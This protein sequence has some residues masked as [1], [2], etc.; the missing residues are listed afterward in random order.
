[1]TAADS[2]PPG[3]LGRWPDER[4]HPW[5]SPEVPGD[6]AFAAAAREVSG[7][8]TCLPGDDEAVPVPTRRLAF[9]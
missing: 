4:H 7:L 1:M 5:L 8:Y 6:E 2:S 3:T 9:G